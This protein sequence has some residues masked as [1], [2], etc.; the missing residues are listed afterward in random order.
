[1]TGHSRANLSL[2]GCCPALKLM[3]PLQPQCLGK[4]LLVPCPQTRVSDQHLGLKSTR[5]FTGKEARRGCSPSSPTCNHQC[6]LFCPHAGKQRQKTALGVFPKGAGVAPGEAR[7]SPP[8]SCTW[9]CWTC[10][11]EEEAVC[12]TAELRVSP[13]LPGN[14]GSSSSPGS[15]WVRHPQ[16]HRSG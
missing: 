13:R 16:H 4:L 2:Q 5:C 1:M 15:R 7:D 12:P 9:A 14:T 10:P 8:G 3:P 11:L 6:C